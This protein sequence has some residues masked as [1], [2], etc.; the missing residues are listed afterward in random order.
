VWH[1]DQKQKKKYSSENSGDPNEHTGYT[2]SESDNDYK[3]G[4]Q[5]TALLYL[6]PSKIPHDI[7]WRDLHI[8][9]MDVIFFTVN[10]T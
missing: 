10:I 6:S 7:I 8:F 9:D 5:S 2:A 4:R 3:N 1:Q